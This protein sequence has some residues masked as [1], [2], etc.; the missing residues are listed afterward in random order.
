MTDEKVSRVHLVRVIGVHVYDGNESRPRVMHNR[1]IYVFEGS[2][3][4][5]RNPRHL[6]R[7]Q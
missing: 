3:A 6:Q 4:V 2:L 5:K 1:A 7:Q